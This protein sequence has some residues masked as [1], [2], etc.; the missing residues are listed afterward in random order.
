MRLVPHGAPSEQGQ[1]DEAPAA[2]RDVAARGRGLQDVRAWLEG[3]VTRSKER[4]GLQ[5]HLVTDEVPPDPSQIH[6][7]KFVGHS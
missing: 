6:L 4:A 5:S 7:P 1:G 2:W 3:I